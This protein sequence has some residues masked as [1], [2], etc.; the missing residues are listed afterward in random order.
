M[1]AMVILT[2]M[3]HTDTSKFSFCSST[4]T[5]TLPTAIPQ[6]NTQ[7]DQ[8]K[9]IVF[10]KTKAELPES[11]ALSAKQCLS[12]FLFLLFKQMF[13]YP[14]FGTRS[15]Q[16][17]S[18]HSKPSFGFK[19]PWNNRAVSHREQRMQGGGALEDLRKSCFY[20]FCSCH[21]YGHYWN[22]GLPI[23]IALKKE[24]RFSR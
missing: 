15:N 4:P 19:W 3:Q 6:A 9:E 10:T 13:V 20:H 21:I 2:H 12:S 24:P 7:T 18:E 8:D 14:D 17:T 16:G 1:F 11:T 5:G 22:P 23:F